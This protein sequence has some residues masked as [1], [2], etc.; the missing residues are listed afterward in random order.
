[1]ASRESTIQCSEAGCISLTVCSLASG[2]SGNATVVKSEEACILFDAGVSMRYTIGCLEKLQIEPDVIDGIF[3]S[4]EHSDHIKSA[5]VLSRN[6]KVPLWSNE[7]TW[8]AAEK[9]LGNVHQQ[10]RFITEKTVLIKD[11]EILPIPVSHD[12]AEPVCFRIRQMGKNI[13]VGIVTDIGIL[14]PPVKHYLHNSELIMLE[15]NFDLDMLVNGTYPENVKL[16][17]LG[18]LGHLSNHEAGES[19]IEL[20][21]KN[22]KHVLLS[23]ISQDNNTPDLAYNTVLKILQR[24]GIMKPNLG[25]TFHNRMS[26]IISLH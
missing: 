26:K 25:L 14:T 23:H 10:K 6:L 16:F 15:S 22:T 17:I 4:H 21:G 9:R 2:S 19:L 7:G 5:G 18:D 11:L 12:A 20:M 3:L 13:Q 24:E 8:V 1:M